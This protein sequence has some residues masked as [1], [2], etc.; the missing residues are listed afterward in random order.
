[1]SKNMPAWRAPGHWQ[2]FLKICPIISV[3]V[4]VQI[5]C[6]GCCPGN[7]PDQMEKN[8]LGIYQASAGHPH[9]H[10]RCPPRWPCGCFFLKGHW[11]II[12][13]A[14]TGH[15]GVACRCLFKKFRLFFPVKI[16]WASTGNLQGNWW[17]PADPSSSLVPCKNWPMPE[18]LSLCVKSGRWVPH[19]FSS[20][21]KNWP[22]TVGVPA[23]CPQ[24][25][26]DFGHYA[27]RPGTGTT[28]RA[29]VTGGLLVFDKY[30]QY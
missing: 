26:A 12:Y 23:W 29:N 8:L 22:V 10:C 27:H 5:A 18:K 11:L 19:A 21:C 2:A 15:L 14:S 28:I 24:R 16:R 25:P 1:M 4:M 13:R 9:M 20:A 3:A 6:E 17:W 30:A 7:F